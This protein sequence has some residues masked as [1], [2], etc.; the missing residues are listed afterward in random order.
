VIVRVLGSAAGGGVPQWNCA[1]A[2]CAAARRGEAPRRTQSS[3]AFSADGA[4]WWLVNVSPDIAVQIE[5][6]PELQPKER[7]GSPIRGFL[8]T[9]ANVDHIGGLAVLRQTHAPGF[10]LYSSTVVREIATAQPAFAPFAQPPHRWHDADASAFVLDGG[11]LRVRTI[12]LDGL[13]PGY[14]GRSRREGAVV[15]YVVEDAASGAAAVFAP[16]F[17]A[18]TEPLRAA[19]AAAGIAF[20]DGSFWSDDEMSAAGLG[21]KRARDL[22]HQPVGGED[23]TL[24]QLGPLAARCVFTHLNNSNPMLRAASTER[25]VVEAADARIAA[26]GFQLTPRASPATR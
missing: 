6:Y 11:A 13:T 17:A 8:L 3:I 21:G 19:I 14:A 15:A 10:D 7:R 2:N 16:V 5:T 25:N 20:L 26:D 24:A 4:S 1:C 9:D 22:G 23:G 12:S 18:L